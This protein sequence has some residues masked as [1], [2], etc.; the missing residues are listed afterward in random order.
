MA[1]NV[2]VYDLENY[3]DN[4]KTVV[5]DIKKITPIGY[6]GDEQWTISCTTTAYSDNTNRTDIQDIYIM[7]MK[8]G[9]AKSSGLVTTDQFTITGANNQLQLK[10]DGDSTWRSI[11]LASGVNMSGD[12]VAEDMENKIRALKDSVDAEYKL[13]YMNA[14]VEYANSRFKIVSGRVSEFYTGA[15]R[16]SVEINP[17]STAAATLG[18]NLPVT[19]LDIASI[20]IRET[21]TVSGYSGGT[22]LALNSGLGSGIIGRAFVITDGTHTEYFLAGSGSTETL[23]NSR[24]IAEGCRVLYDTDIGVFLRPNAPEIIFDCPGFLPDFSLELYL[25]LLP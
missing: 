19:S 18:F 2:S 5:I 6:E 24:V 3:P 20:Q 17:S 1:V 16:S 22:T 14:S 25:L 11:T 15:N 21:T 7:N 13:S 4:A 8:A 23:I 9:W 10:I 12:A